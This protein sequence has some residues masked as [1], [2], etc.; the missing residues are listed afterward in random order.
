MWGGDGAGVMKKGREV[1][2]GEGDN[3]WG[4]GSHVPHHETY[5]LELGGFRVKCGGGGF[6]D[7]RPGGKRGEEG[8][9]GRGEERRRGEDG[10]GGGQGVGGPLFFIYH[11]N[12]VRS[13]GIW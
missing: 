7:P 8:K 4:K 9:R 13:Q 2:M 6:F 11:K 10:R 5:S 1:K 3:K 12:A